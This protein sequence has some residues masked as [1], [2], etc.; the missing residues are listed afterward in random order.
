MSYLHANHVEGD[1][2]LANTDMPMN[3]RMEIVSLTQVASAHR[4]MWVGSLEAEF[5]TPHGDCHEKKLT[6]QLAI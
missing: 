3:F 5:S 2:K 6:A 4:G 1:K